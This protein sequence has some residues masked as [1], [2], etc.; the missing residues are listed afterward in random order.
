MDL[1]KLQRNLTGEEVNQ[2]VLKEKHLDNLILIMPQEY[3]E[4]WAIITHLQTSCCRSRLSSVISICIHYC[5]FK[6]NVVYKNY[7]NFSDMKLLMLQVYACVCG[8]MQCV[9][10]DVCHILWDLQYHDSWYT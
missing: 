6:I 10:F 5:V 9:A 7:C 4:C 2:G 3:V 8:Y 1:K